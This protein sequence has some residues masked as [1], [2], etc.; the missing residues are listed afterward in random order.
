MASRVDKRTALALPFFR[1][2][3]LARVMPTRSASSVTLIFLLANIISMLMM[4]AM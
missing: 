2:E 1:M 4:I 3:R